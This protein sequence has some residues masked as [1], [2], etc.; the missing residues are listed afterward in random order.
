MTV[1]RL[2]PKPTIAQSIARDPVLEGVERQLVVDKVYAQSPMP[3]G[4]WEITEDANALRWNLMLARVR[5]TIDPRRFDYERLT[6]RAQL[7]PRLSYNPT[8]SHFTSWGYS[9]CGV[10]R[11]QSNLLRGLAAEAAIFKER[12]PR[13]S[14]GNWELIHNG[15]SLARR[16]EPSQRDA[17]DPVT[18]AP[19][20]QIS[21]LSILGRP[22]RANPDLVFR[23]RRLDG[24][25]T[26]SGR[27]RIV[28]VEIK[29]STAPIPP[30][31]WPNTR[32]QLWAYSKIDDFANAREIILVGEVWHA[33]RRSCGLRRSVTWQ[34]DDALLEEECSALFSAYS[35]QDRRSHAAH[36]SS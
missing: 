18:A 7:R 31:L 27:E 9:L 34:S 29:G 36:D 12:V 4:R 16:Q 19:G 10:E 20:F 21:S 24:S 35:A 32:A 25:T 15:M 2:I 14:H 11:K 6:R 3:Y 5:P 28:I 26:P 30:D 13:P 8:V 33:L 23:E 1:H 22:L 17:H